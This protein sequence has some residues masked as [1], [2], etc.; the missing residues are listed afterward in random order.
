MIADGR[1]IPALGGGTAGDLLDYLAR[2]P[3]E[4]PDPE[5]KAT[6]ALL[7]MREEER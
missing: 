6:K 5:S 3:E 2:L 7:E 4:E 1:V